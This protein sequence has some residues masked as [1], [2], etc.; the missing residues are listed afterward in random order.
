MS[1]FDKHELLEFLDDTYNTEIDNGKSKLTAL[2]ITRKEYKSWVG[3]FAAGL[4]EQIKLNDILDPNL[5]IGLP[6]HIPAAT[7]M[8]ALSHNLEALCSPFYHPLAEGIAIEGARLVK[9]YLPRAVKDGSDIE[10]RTQMLVASM[11]GATAFQ[12][13]LGAMH[14]LAHPLGALYDAHH[15][16]LN[17]ILMPYVLQANREVIEERIVRLARYMDLEDC[18][19]DGFLNWVLE[20]RSLLKIPHSLSQINIDTQQ[21]T[22]VATMATE[23]PSAGGNPI[24]FTTDQYQQIF[25]NAVKGEL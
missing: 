17:A 11:M 2:R 24:K 13:G 3:D 10:A 19:F 25:I 5:K 9:D 4:K 21:Q 22:L 12:K 6:S 1:L 20:M 7:G 15:G 8:D 16:L 14:A 23:D 18:S